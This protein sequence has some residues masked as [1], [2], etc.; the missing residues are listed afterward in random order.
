MPIYEYECR[1]HGEFELIRN[2]QEARLS[3]SCPDCGATCGRIV[4]AP[5]IVG[6]PKATLV[7][8]E[9]NERSQHEPRVATRGH[10][11]S[12]SCN[13]GGRAKDGPP[14]R[15]VAQRYTGARPWVIEHA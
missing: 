14:K 12:A 15:R 2:V 11:C 4:S 1:K 3:G 9:R 7:A 13:H 8:H 5:H 6:L 10:V